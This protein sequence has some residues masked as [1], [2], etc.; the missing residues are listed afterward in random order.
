MSL[1]KFV[2]VLEVLFGTSLLALFVTVEDSTIQFQG[3][4]YAH[5]GH[6]GTG[7]YALQHVH[8]INSG[9]PQLDNANAN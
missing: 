2:H 4:V 3:I 7:I 9:T 6:H 8:Q 1:Q 5:Q